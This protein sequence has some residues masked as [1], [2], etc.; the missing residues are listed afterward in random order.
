[1]PNMVLMAP[2]DAADLPAMLDFALKFDG[3]CSLRYPKAN[4]VTI[5]REQTPIELGRS[6][7][8]RTGAD[9]CIVVC[10]A[11]VRRALEASDRL[12]AEGLDVG[13][14]NARFLKPF[15]TEAIV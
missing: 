10:G 15:D 14:I 9:G 2:G 5:E 6:E 3:P 1:F 4:A 13:V 8:I 11:L 7:T 12:R